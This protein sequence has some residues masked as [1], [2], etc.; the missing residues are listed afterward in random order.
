[1]RHRSRA[2]RSLTN[3]PQR[4]LAGFVG[5]KY[6]KN[7]SISV[8]RAYGYHDTQSSL[9]AGARCDKSAE[10]SALP[11]LPGRHRAL[12]GPAVHNPQGKCRQCVNCN[13]RCVKKS[14]DEPCTF[15]LQWSSDWP[16]CC[17]I[18]WILA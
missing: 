6:V 4:D 2:F 7:L 5:G 11:G 3:P 16:D 17:K 18:G 13:S 9:S 8:E 15:W 10:S 14:A 12:T 1:M